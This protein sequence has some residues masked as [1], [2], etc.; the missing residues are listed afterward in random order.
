MNLKKLFAALTGLWRNAA[1]ISE[2]TSANNHEKIPAT[3]RRLYAQMRRQYVFRVN[4]L[5]DQTE[6]ALADSENKLFQ[7]IDKRVMN[8]IT[9]DMLSQ[10]ISCLDRDVKRFIES[11]TLETYH[12][13]RNYFENLPAWDGTDR[14]T[15]LA[16]RVSDDELWTRLFHIWLLS[17]TARWMGYGD[18]KHANSVAPIL[19]STEQG[20]GKST[21]ARL[22]IPKELENYYTDS[23]DMANIA[24]C[25]RKL[26]TYGL[27]NLDEFDKISERKMPLLKNLM[28][29][30][31]VN[32]RRPYGSADLHLDRIASFIGTS[33]RRD[34]LS[35]VSGSRRF[36]CVEVDKIIDTSDIDHS[37]LYAQLKDSL[38]RG[39]RHWFSKREEAEMQ[40]RNKLFYRQSP[41]EELI[42]KTFDTVSE[43]SEGARLWSSV[44]IF[45]T[46]KQLHPAAMAGMTSYKLSRILPGLLPK[47]HTEYGRGYMLKRK[48]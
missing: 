40:R 29:M 12:P 15:P 33:N 18:N 37:Q 9:M 32:M 45:N 38:L 19:I 35:D 2:K 21:F 48:I 16:R 34:L 46:L 6:M 3:V 39:A 26:T 47:V 44:D 36:L 17:M 22:L 23:Y 7:R 24:T 14:V 27:I 31:A 4:M 43:H 8:G 30:A 10:G 28:Q 42:A 13:F 5:T 1:S 41:V 25:E 20:V 11:D